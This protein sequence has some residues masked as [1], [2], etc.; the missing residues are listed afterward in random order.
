MPQGRSFLAKSDKPFQIL[1][2]I[3]RSAHYRL[4]Q[5]ESTPAVIPIDRYRAMTPEG[6]VKHTLLSGWDLARLA[7]RPTLPHHF[8]SDFMGKS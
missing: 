5:P 8:G 3:V 4:G 2:F 1:P 7:E 6:V